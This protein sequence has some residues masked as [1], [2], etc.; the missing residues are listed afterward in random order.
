M[1]FPA[2]TPLLIV[3]SRT[4]LAVASTLEE[5]ASPPA[6]GETLTDS[7]ENDTTVVNTQGT[8]RGAGAGERD[9]R[10]LAP[11]AEAYRGAYSRDTQTPESFAALRMNG[12]AWTTSR[13]RYT[14]RSRRI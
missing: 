13:V 10:C 1:P 2:E 4:L 5:G 9:I 7:H 6:W 11:P 14:G 8:Q 3:F 12:E